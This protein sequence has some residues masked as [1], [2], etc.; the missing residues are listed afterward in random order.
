MKKYEFT[1]EIINHRGRTLHRIRAKISFGNVTKGSIGGFVESEDNLSDDGCSWIFGNAMVYDC[2]MIY[3]DAIVYDDAKIHGKAEVFGHSQVYGIA[4]VCGNAWI[5]ENASVCCNACVYGNSWVFGNSLVNG[6]AKIYG[7]A[8]VSGDSW[9]FGE[10]RV[11]GDA[12]ICGNAMLKSDCHYC[13]VGPC[14]SRNG[15]TTFFRCN[16]GNIRVKCGC[17]YGNLEEFKIK[18]LQ[19]HKNSKHANVYFAAIE[20]A[21]NQINEVQY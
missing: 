15:F 20:F 13:I 19:T 1:G 4:E 11:Y 5:F 3:G 21:K 6:N 14:G 7:D 18:I 8:R 17:F 2:A 16:D 9:I 12:Y 10:T